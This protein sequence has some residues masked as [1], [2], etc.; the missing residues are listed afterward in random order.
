MNKRIHR[1]RIRYRYGGAV[2]DSVS[3]NTV[4]PRSDTTDEVFPIPL[5]CASLHG[6]H[7]R[8][9][10]WN[11]SRCPFSSSRHLFSS[12]SPPGLDDNFHMYPSSSSR[13]RRS[14]VTVRATPHPPLG[15]ST[16]ISLTP[17]SCPP[18]NL[19]R[20]CWIFTS[21]S[22]VWRRCDAS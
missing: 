6:F 9:A 22:S 15:S 8:P 2:D 17:R 13:R 14:C 11:A 3:L 21:S 10:W 16:D 12:F 5:S 4:R 7:R 20:T 18:T 1:T 19:L